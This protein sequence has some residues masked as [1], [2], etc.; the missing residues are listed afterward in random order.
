MSDDEND[1]EEWV[2]PPQQRHGTFL[3]F[4]FEGAHERVS[5]MLELIAAWLR[6]C[7]EYQLEQIAVSTDEDGWSLLS[8]TVQE[9]MPG[10]LMQAL[11]AAGHPD[12]AAGVAELVKEHGVREGMHRLGLAYQ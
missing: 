2:L 6:G 7:A 10:D 5:E 1:I 3:V 11:T 12:L 4:D 9:L 8:V